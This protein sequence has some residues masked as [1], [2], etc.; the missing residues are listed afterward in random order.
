MLRMRETEPKERT[1]LTYDLEW[2]PSD[3]SEKSEDREV[4]DPLETRLCGLYD[5][6]EYRAFRTIGTFLDYV[7]SAEYAGKWFYAHAG[8]LAD[9]T[10]LL[11]SIGK[12]HRYRVQGAFSGSSL[13]IVRVTRGDKTWHFIDSLWLL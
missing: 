10:F 5:G 4:S 7:L 2:Y 6:C 1:F 8:G 12:N 11:N 9:M 3:L 13:I